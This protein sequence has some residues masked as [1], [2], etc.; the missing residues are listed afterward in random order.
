MGKIKIDADMLATALEDHSETYNWFLDRRTGEIFM[1]AD[2][3]D[4]E[5]PDKH[6]TDKIES[7]PDRFLY[8]E[9][10]ESHVSFGA[11]E[12]FIAELDGDDSKSAL[13]NSLNFTQPFKA[14]KNALCNYP[15]ARQ[16][17]FEFHSHWMFEKAKEWLQEE[18]LEA[19]LYNSPNGG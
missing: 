16:Q 15:D 10:L 11:M 8:I 19:E 14:F 9:P 6:D 17:W 18:G 7:Q 1:C 5:P 3:P 13:V 2:E 12:D 4:G